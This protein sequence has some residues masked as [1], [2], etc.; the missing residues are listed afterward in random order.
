MDSNTVC[1]A[2]T[3]RGLPLWRGL[4]IACCAATALSAGDVEIYERYRSPV[5]TPAGGSVQAYVVHARVVYP[6][7]IGRV[8]DAFHDRLHVSA[9]VS[10]IDREEVV[11]TECSLDHCTVGLRVVIE[12][13]GALELGYDLDATVD[14]NPDGSVVMEWTKVRGTPIIRHLWGRME[15]RRLAPEQTELDYRIAVGAT[16]L[17]LDRLATKTANYLGIVGDVLAEDHQGCDSLWRALGPERSSGG[18]TPPAD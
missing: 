6:Y 2:R 15:L 8:L 3:A 4:A 7:S 5:Q 17:T 11:A 18:T 16:L 14:R 1:S 12:D 9:R 13:F 10:D